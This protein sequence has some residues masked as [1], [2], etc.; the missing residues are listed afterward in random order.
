MC[1]ACLPKVIVAGL[2]VFAQ[3]LGVTSLGWFDLEG[4]G[5][6]GICGFGFEGLTWGTVSNT[7]TVP[8]VMENLK[9]QGMISQN[10]LGV[11][12]HAEPGSVCFSDIICF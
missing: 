8:T 9:S 5:F 12:L 3:S 6:D 2:P 1:L 7:D 4:A 11:F 10:V